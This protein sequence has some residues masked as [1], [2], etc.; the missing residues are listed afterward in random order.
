[1]TRFQRKY[2]DRERSELAVA[3][4]RLVGPSTLKYVVK[5]LYQEEGKDNVHPNCRA[6]FLRKA[7]KARTPENRKLLMEIIEDKSFEKLDLQSL[8]TIIDVVND[9]NEKPI[10]DTFPLRYHSKNDR[11][12]WRAAV[13]SSIPKWNK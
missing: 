1:M 3:M 9:W 4:W 11:D 13:I 10:V 6:A 12:V 5:W 7:P 2:D 8:R